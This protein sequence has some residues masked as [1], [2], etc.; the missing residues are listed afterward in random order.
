MYNKLMFNSYICTDESCGD[1]ECNVQP[2]TWN[3]NQETLC[4]TP[5]QQISPM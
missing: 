3:I 4:A 5:M 1:Q 2:H